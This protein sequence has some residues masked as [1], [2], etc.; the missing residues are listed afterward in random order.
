M[1][2]SSWRH[3]FYRARFAPRGLHLGPDVYSDSRC[4]VGSQPK[5]FDY[6]E[7]QASSGTGC[8]GRRP[9]AQLELAED[10]TVEPTGI[11]FTDLQL[12]YGSGNSFKTSD[13]MIWSDDKPDL[14]VG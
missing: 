1:L 3:P 8:A 11:S 5:N 10:V 2:A 12:K 6:T 7:T 9:Q 13:V 14:S 4:L